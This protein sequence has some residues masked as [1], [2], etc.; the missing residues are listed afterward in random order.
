MRRLY[1]FEPTIELEDG[2]LRLKAHLEPE[3]AL[4]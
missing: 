4:P 3:E 2:L 1:S